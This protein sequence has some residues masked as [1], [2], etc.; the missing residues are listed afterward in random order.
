[1]K[2][3]ILSIIAAAV[4]AARAPYLE[5]ILWR[6]ASSPRI[7]TV[8]KQ[9]QSGEKDAAAKFWDEMKV[10]GTPLIEQ[11][12]N[13]RQHVLVTFLYRAETPVKGVVLMAQLY[14]QDNRDDSLRVLSN[15]PDTDI[16]YKKYWMRND[17]LFTYSLV[18]N[19]TTQSLAYNSELQLQDPLNPKY[20]AL[21]T[22][23]GK[24]VVELP[25]AGKQPWILANT[26]VPRGKLEEV[27]I[28]SKVLNS[29]RRFWIY[30]P[31]G[32]DAKKASPY[33]M[34]VCFAGWVYSQSEF[35]PTPTIPTT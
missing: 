23:V 2:S 16:W 4:F 7:E 26:A 22:N 29:P 19:P 13:D 14:V 31:A 32:Y 33:P 9:V 24:S 11:I 6:D 25:A 27:E 1:M 5:E 12:P 34:L 18:P 8:R 3:I 20:I 30:T 21:G 17:M 35:V 15:L 10:R 28:K